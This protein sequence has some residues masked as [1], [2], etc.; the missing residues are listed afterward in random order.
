MKQE[1]E[2]TGSSSTNESITNNKDAFCFFQPTDKSFF[3][4]MLRS[5]FLQHKLNRTPLW[6]I[7]KRNRLLKK[8]FG[9]IDG[10]PYCIY[11]PL[12]VQQG[13]NIHIGKNFLCNYNLTILDHAKVTI[14]DNVLIAPNVSILTVSHPMIAEQRIARRFPNSFE[15]QSRGDWEIIRPVH[16]G[17]N[18][19]IA[20]D[21]IICPGVTIGDN[22]VIGAGSV[23]TKNIPPNVLAYGVP[24]R[25]IREITDEDRLDF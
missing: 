4:T 19:W 15:M 9:S 24:C 2:F 14:G 3:W 8:L 1:K 18:V 6:R 23:V 17:N 22:S 13:N 21:A 20:T 11:S 12:H 7:K 10:V 16:I 5:E 25:V